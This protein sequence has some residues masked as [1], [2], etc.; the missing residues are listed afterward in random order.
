[1]QSHRYLPLC[2]TILDWGRATITRYENHQV[3]DRA[4]DDVLRKINLDPKWF[5]L[6]ML[7]RAEGRISEKAFSKYRHEAS[8]QFKKKKKSIS[9]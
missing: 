4:H 8:S 9:N 6:E 7:E 2:Y 3:Q 5:F 1:M